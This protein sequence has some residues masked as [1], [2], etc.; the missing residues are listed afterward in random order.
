MD[1]RECVIVVTGAS[2]GIGN[3][4]ATFLAK[5]GN[6][7]YGTCRNPSAYSRKADEFFEMLPMDISDS[8]SVSK[9]A[10]KIYTA[11]GTVDSIVCCAGSGLVGAIEDCSLDEAQSVMNVNYFGTLR[12]IKAFLPR[13]RE[14]GK[15]RILVVGALEGIAA[16][17]YQGLY[18]ASEF[19]LA[20]L[21]EAL[22]LEVAGF[23]I[24]VGIIALG[25]FRT[26]FGQK[27]LLAA[28]ASESSPYRAKLETALGVLSKDETKG[29]EPLV[30]ARVIHAALMA[31]HLPLRRT[32]GSLSRLILVNSK[33]WRPSHNF[34]RALRKYYRLR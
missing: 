11:A 33:R 30:A 1:K 12:T 5:K 7:V 16:T 28:G 18:S 15:G 29:L 14:A 13:M 25:S 6:R 9:A 4:C 2:S 31:R 20:G 8:S 34:E 10:E 23:G 24:E 26:A 22:R 19:A 21:V 3:A 17:P 32:I 27:R